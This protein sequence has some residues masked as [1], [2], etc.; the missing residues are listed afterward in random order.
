MRLFI[1]AGAAEHEYAIAIAVAIIAL[2]PRVAA[3][4]EMLIGIICG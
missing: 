4:P 1:D 2:P 3:P